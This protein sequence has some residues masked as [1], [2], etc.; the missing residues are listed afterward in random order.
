[1]SKRVRTGIG[2]DSHRF[3]PP[4]SSK[5]CVIAGIIFEGVPGFNANS[6][7][8]IVFHAICNAITSLTGILI[9]GDIADDLCLKDGI[10]DSEIFL[11][12]AVKTLGRQEVS[13]VAVTIEAKKP[14][15][16]EHILKMRTNIARVMNLDVS[17]V[18]ITATSGE[19]LTDF[20]CGDG[21]QSFAIVTTEETLEEIR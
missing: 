9:L 5:P 4:D 16:K 18:G 20:G 12:E 8:D 17:Q 2:Q 6:D 1:M 14:K 10:T 13:H 21:V 19:G 3:L 7:G 15:M 11:V